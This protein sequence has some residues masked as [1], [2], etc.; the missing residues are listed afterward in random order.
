MFR[1]PWP[2]SPRPIA[3]R[4]APRPPPAAPAPRDAGSRAKRSRAGA[5]DPDGGDDGSPCRMLYCH[6]SG[7]SSAPLGPSAQNLQK[8]TGYGC[9]GD[10][11]DK[12]LLTFLPFEIYLR[13]NVRSILLRGTMRRANV[14]LQADR[15]DE[16]LVAAQACFAR[17]GFH[18]TSMQEICT[19][20]GMSPGSLYRYFRSKED[21]IA[22]IAERDRAETAQQFAA[23]GQGNFFDG[24]A[25]LAQHHLV[26]RSLEE[27]ALCA[28]IMAESR[29]NPAVA[30]IYQNMEADVRA[31]FIA[32]LQRAAERGEVRRDL[33]LDGVVTVLFALADGLSWRRA[34]EPAFNTEA[35]MP[36]VLRMV[37]QVLNPL[38]QNDNKVG[39]QS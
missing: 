8:T 20:A 15:R 28:E 13:M 22:A 4:S 3:P 30:R 27:V 26:E 32:L 38:P 1:S 21:I 24:L 29:R 7:K 34:V 25:A 14:Q 12:T 37:E 33:D 17:S 39:G 16:I 6:S 23:L 10:A 36:L 2:R 19:E 11:A 31:R 5:Y 35:V 9:R 18:Q